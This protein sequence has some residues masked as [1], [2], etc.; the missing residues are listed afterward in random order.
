[1]SPGTEQFKLDQDAIQNF[2][3]SEKMQHYEQKFN[4][5]INS[6]SSSLNDDSEVRKEDKDAGPTSEL[7]YWRSR[8]QKITNWSEQ[9]K[10]KDFQVVKVNL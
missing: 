5:W 2:N 9:L 7:V 8:M 3:E 6:I 1:M 4:E 10:S